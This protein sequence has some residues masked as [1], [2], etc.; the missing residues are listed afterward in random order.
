MDE[1]D[2]IFHLRITDNGHSTSKLVK[3]GGGIS[4]M[5]EKMKPFGVVLHVAAYPRFVLSID[6]PGGDKIA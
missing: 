6:L 2:G 4:G 3:E 1:S 5:R